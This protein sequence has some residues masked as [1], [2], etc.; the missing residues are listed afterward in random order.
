MYFV[1]SKHTT[2]PIHL[3]WLDLITIQILHKEYELQRMYVLNN[4]R[5]A[6]MQT[7]KPLIPEPS[8]YEV[9]IATEELGRYKLLGIDQ[10]PQN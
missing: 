10:I 2:H 4:V 3:N 8:S 7:A 9:E 5:W 1:P 6:Q